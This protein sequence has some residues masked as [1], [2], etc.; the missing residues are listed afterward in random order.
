M[1]VGS[2]VKENKIN[3]EKANCITEESNRKI[4]ASR[5]TEG[6]LVTVRV[7]EP[8][9][10]AVVPPELDG[11]NCASMMI[12]RKN[13]LFDSHWLCF[14]MNSGLGISQIRNVQYGTA[15]KQFNICDAVNFLYPFPSY[16]EQNSIANVL[17]DVGDLITSL[18]KLITKKRA[19]KTAAMQQL[20]TGK[21]RLPPFDLTHTGYKR[22]ELGE[23]PEDWEVVEFGSLLTE[24]RNGF[25]FSASGYVTSGV[26]IITMAQIGLSGQ[27]QFIETRVSRW[28]KD[29]FNQLKDFWVRNGDLIIAM[30]DVTP[31]KN[32]IGQMAIVKLNQIALLNQRVGLL[33]LKPKIASSKFYSYLSCL[34]VWKI[35]C[36]GV[37]SLGVQANIS[38]AD[39]RKAVVYLPSYEEQN[40]IADVLSDMDKELDALEQR[41]NKTQQLKQGMMQELLTG[42]TRLI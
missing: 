23:I 30:T 3:W 24:F 36:K 12:V 41:L 38:T 13:N 28:S 31:D 8:G 6:D 26:P 35:Y 37:A 7:G 40:V 9:I 42:R 11:C 17:S 10:T 21:K 18:E 33:R 4:P 29:T 27:F 20:L 1:L 34:P 19:I 15:Q 25:S 22:T 14:I 16:K 2:T 32:L 5:L 39:I